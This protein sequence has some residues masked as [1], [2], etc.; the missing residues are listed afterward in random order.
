MDKDEGGERG[1]G[2]GGGEEEEGVVPL[3]KSRDPHLAGRE[4]TF[5]LE[6]CEGFK[7]LSRSFS[8]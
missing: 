4:T 8:N 1:G 7:F 6:T 3:L 5:R 2:G